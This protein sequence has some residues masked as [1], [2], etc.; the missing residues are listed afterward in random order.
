MKAAKTPTA[1]ATTAAKETRE[2]EATTIAAVE[3]GMAWRR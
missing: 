2:K 1:A 3:T